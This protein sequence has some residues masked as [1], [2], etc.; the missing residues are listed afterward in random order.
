MLYPRA[1]RSFF[2]LENMKSLRTCT[3]YGRAKVKFK[4][5]RLENKKLNW[6]G[7]YHHICSESDLKSFELQKGNS[8]KAEEEEYKQNLPIRVGFRYVR[9]WQNVSTWRGTIKLCNGNM[10]WM[11]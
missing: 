4:K 7:C 8:E 1:K 5:E 9:Y 3:Q 2:K 10:E 11:D 6:K